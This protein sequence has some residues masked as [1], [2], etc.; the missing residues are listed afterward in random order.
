MSAIAALSGQQRTDTD[1][2]T[3]KTALRAETEPTQDAAAA[4]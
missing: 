3:Y 2:A 4:S 1:A